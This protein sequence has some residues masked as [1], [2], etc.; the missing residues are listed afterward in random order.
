MDDIEYI[1]GHPCNALL[2]G[3]KKGT[4]LERRFTSN[5]IESDT[6]N[7]SDQIG[8]TYKSVTKMRCG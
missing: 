2:L 4:N 1:S 5:Q 6:K 7:S 3:H 8:Q